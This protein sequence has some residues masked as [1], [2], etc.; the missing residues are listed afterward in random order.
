M[1]TFLEPL[2]ELEEMRLLREA[3][4]KNKKIYDVSGCID[5]Q[6]A[7]LIYGIGEGNPFR[8]IVTF[9]EMKAKQLLEEYR[10]FDPDT[11]YYPAKDLLFYQ[12]DIRGNALTRQRMEAVRAVLERPEVT[13]ITTIDALMN[14]IPSREKYMEG[15]FSVSVGDVLD[16]EEIRS[17]LLKLGYEYTSQVEHGGEFA[18]RGGILDIFPLTEE[19]PVRI[20]LWGDEVDSLRY[21]DAQSQK[22]VDNADSVTVYPALELVLDEREVEEGLAAMEADGKALYEK[23]RREM[24]TEEAHRLKSMV[25][26]VVEETREW[27][28]SQELETHLTYFCR[29]T[30]SLLDLMPKD[31]LVFLDEESRLEERAKVVAREFSESMTSRLE[32]GY[33][34]P[35]QMEMLFPPEEIFGKLCGFRGVTLSA[36]ETKDGWIKR[37]G[38]YH[39]RC[40]SVGSYN[41]HFELLVKD[42][43]KYRRQKYRVLLLSPS[44]SRAKRLAQELMDQGLSSFYSEDRDHAINPGEIM[45]TPGTLGRGFAYPDSRFV[46]LT[47]GDIFGQHYRKKKKKVKHYEGEKITGFS[48]LHVGDYVVHE[49]HGLG[50]YQ[51]IEKMEVD[52]VVKDYIKISYAKGGNLYIL[53]TQ[54]DS[55]AKYSGQEGKKPKLNTLGTQEW[56]KTRERVRSAV[57]VVA[58][59]LVELYARRQ[60]GNGYVYGPDT[61]WQ[62]EFEETFPY[63]ETEGQLAA[64]EAVKQDMMSTKIMD[65]LICGDVGYGKTEIAIRAA[66]KAVQEGKQVVY[67]VPTTILAQQHYNT[68]VQRMAAYPVQIGLLCRFRTAAEQKKTIEG[69]KK[70]TVDIVIGTHRLLS[71]DVGFKD[72]GLLIIDEEQRF[73]VGH[74]EKIKK[75]K[76]T[77]DVMSLSAT[78]IPRTLHMSLIGIRDMSVLEEAPMER[79]PIQTF[80]FE[81]NEEMI[82]EAIARELSRGGQVYYVFNRIQQIGEMAAKIQSLVPEA[83]V[84]YAH[85]R[86]AETQLERI[87]YDFVNQE[88]DVLVS[89]TIIEIGMDI[90]NVNT[91]IIHDADNMGLSQL[92]QLRGRVGRSNRTAYAFLMYRKDKMLKEVAEKRLAAIKEFTEL[93]SGFKIAMRDLE[94]RGAGNLLGEEQHGHMEAVGYD[95][96]CKMLGEAVKREKGIPQE[97]DFFTVVELPVD[98]Y[99]PPSYITA[100]SQRL[101]IYKRIAEIASEEEREDMLDELIDRFGE[102]PKPV[103]N[104]LLVAKLRMEAHRAYI[105][106]I[107]QKEDT[108]RLALY[109]KARLR[110]EEF[111][112]LLEQFAPYVAFSADAKHPAFLYHLA[113]NSRQKTRDTM[114]S[115]L[116]FVRRLQE[117]ALD[118][119]EI[120]PGQTGN[121]IAR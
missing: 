16:L 53:A 64:I 77:V 115:V 52:K 13:V 29:E 19:N 55:I 83:N 63:E 113:K 8:L 70:G 69:L 116:E 102:P 35:R 95:L 94:I 46:L 57:G 18:L 47:E 96:Y 89:T 23:F 40:Q 68:F 60:N 50:I 78:P 43:Q 75:M 66:F 24:K 72:L 25:E 100:E 38:R 15:I 104:L 74:K 108:I 114:D 4:T 76:E 37:A 93:G 119:S 22:S 31:T 86:M 39:I 109:E 1:K 107:S 91:I 106:E 49:N 84:A 44:R 27:G 80:V 87:M 62:K 12:S 98:A 51:G 34:L 118:P 58:K 110:P 97:E 67:L 81:Y 90:S 36:L 121:G 17:R 33:L 105:T 59:D 21:F 7:H 112:H 82:R 30:Y 20:E 120:P 79:Q 9:D 117:T 42:L 5:V 48:D 41:Q 56:T 26:Q 10:F 65:R 3:L 85:G 28:L 111:P 14:R 32:K 11:V 99:L 2:Q 92:Y 101:D 6:K 71:K 61:V 54:L 45:V 88:I 103:Q 73:G